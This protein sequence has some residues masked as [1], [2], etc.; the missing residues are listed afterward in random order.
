MLRI[1]DIR[2][3][4]DETLVGLTPNT[5][6]IKPVHV[7]NGLFRTVLGTIHD[8]A[9]LNRF[10]IHQKHDGSVPKGHDGDSVLAWLTAN[11]RISEDAADNG[12]LQVLRVLLR[13]VVNA[14]NGVFLHRDLMESYTG[15]YFPLVTAD[16]IAQSAGEFIGEWLRQCNIPLLETIKEMLQQPDD[17]ISI[18]V[19]PLVEDRSTRFVPKWG[20]PFDKFFRIVPSDVRSL[21]TGLE[22]A[23]TT[24]TS[25]VATHPNKLH[26][27]RLIVLFSSFVVMRHL[28]SLERCYVPSTGSVPPFLL[29]FCDGSS[30]P[31]AA[32]SL[33]SYT[34]ACQSVSMFYTWAFSEYLKSRFGSLEEIARED[35]PCYKTNQPKKEWV[36]I[37][38][39]TLAEAAESDDTF[40]TCGRALYD[41][42]ATEAE[43]DPVRYIRQ[44]G[45]RSGLLWPPE[46]LRPAKRFVVQQDLLEALIRASILPGETVGLPELQQR[47]W[48]RFGI[49]VGGRAEDQEILLKSG[50]YEADGSALQANRDR[51]ATRLSSLSFARLLADGVLQ[52]ELGGASH[53]RP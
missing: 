49:V 18:L 40:L 13:K 22:E 36:E 35:V 27:L 47:L 15:G 33:K 24:L 29:D 28:T 41:I 10:V 5:R 21:W 19:Q 12:Q 25:H 8:T 42:L 32:A 9:V 43:G 51:F 3:R 52:V 17:P 46:N 39:V 34:N 1:E 53:D 6:S 16:R 4:T 2:N 23:A 11:G 44:L 50:I 30:A 20:L 31:V 26:A 7:A 45:N 37:W 38:H 14:D 48:R